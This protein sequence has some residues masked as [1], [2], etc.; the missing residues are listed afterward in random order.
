MTT[1]RNHFKKQHKTLSFFCPGPAS[2]SGSFD[3]NINDFFY[4]VK[5]DF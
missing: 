3:Y 1:T 2:E 5:I 4:A